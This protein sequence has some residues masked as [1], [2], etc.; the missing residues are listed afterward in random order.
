MEYESAKELADR[1]GV[2]IR[3]IQKRAAAGKIPGAVK[4]GRD[5]KIPV[6]QEECE[7]EA[8]RMDWE[9][10]ITDIGI[11][12]EVPKAANLMHIPM[13]LLHSAFPIGHCLEY[14]HKIPDTDDRAIALGEYYYFSGQAEKAAETVE[15]YLDHADASLRLSAALIY[16]FTNLTLGYIYRTQF[17]V[18]II[19]QEMFERLQPDSPEQN[20]AMGIFMS[21]AATVLLHLPLWETP[22]LE[23]YI[24]YLSGGLRV[25]ACYLLAHKAYL[26]EN[27][28]RALTIADMTL[29]MS[30][31]FYPIA[32]IYMDNVATMALMNLMRVEE[33]KERFAKAWSYAKPDHLIE[34]FGEHHGLLQGM[35]EVSLK[36]NEPE[37]FQQIIDIVYRFSSGWRKVHKLVVN[38]EV[39]DNLSTTEFT[40]AMLYS[41]KWTIKEIAHHM[42]V[43]ERTIKNYL[44]SVYNKLGIN[45]RK[46]LKQYMLQ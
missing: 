30:D 39:A 7:S 25:F 46:D 38:K 4:L 5:W 8:I 20:K 26:E 37:A 13:P 9:E 28:E 33:A 2:T 1:L 23:E 29:A 10:C 45:N 15:P 40:V 11:R 27:Y 24:K 42:D 12:S 17:A 19:K 43:S 16:A 32:T 44:A 21:T 34:A 18:N 6:N 3:T 22:P 14:I 31:Q 41:R 36:E 35:V